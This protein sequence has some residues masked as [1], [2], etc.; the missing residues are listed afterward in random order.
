MPELDGYGVIAALRA[1]TETAAIPFSSS[2][3]PEAKIQI[4]AMG[5]TLGPVIISQYQ[6]SNLI[7]LAPS[8]RV[9]RRC[10]V[11]LKDKN[12]SEH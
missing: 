9:L 12:R 5:R 8:D 4:L 1:D 11:A 6:S 7:S 10:L 3:R 2:S